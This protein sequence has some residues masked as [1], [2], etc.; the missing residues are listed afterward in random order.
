M[1]DIMKYILKPQETTA[2]P[3]AFIPTQSNNWNEISAELFA[4][5][6]GIRLSDNHWDI[7][8]YLRDYYQSKGVPA[9]SRLLLETMVTEFAPDG[10][11]LYLFRLFPKGPVCQACKIAGL[12]APDDC[13]HKEVH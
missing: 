1:V 5:D 3:Y 10:G 4:D 8:H 13:Y 2:D 11:K 7:I 12:P 6:D 9:S